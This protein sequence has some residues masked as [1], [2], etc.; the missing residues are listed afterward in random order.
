M[1]TFSTTQLATECT[2]LGANVAMFTVAKHHT[3]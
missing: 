1:R 3:D 2:H